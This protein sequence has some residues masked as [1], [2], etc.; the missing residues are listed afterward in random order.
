VFS[1]ILKLFPRHE[2]ESLAHKHHQ[3]QKLRKITRWS[4]F[5]SLGLA[6]LAGRVSLRDVVSNLRAQANKYITWAVVT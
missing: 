3:G 4:Q 6:Q 5:V 2:F 1:Q